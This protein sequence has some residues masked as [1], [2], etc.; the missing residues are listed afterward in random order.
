M[1]SLLLIQSNKPNRQVEVSEVE[2]FGNNS[3]VDMISQTN[4]GC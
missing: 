2:L 3:P 4:G 1:A